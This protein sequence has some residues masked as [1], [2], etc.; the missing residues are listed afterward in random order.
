AAI[1]GI[2]PTLYEAAKIDGA[3]KF[4]QIWHITLPGIR[5]MIALLAMLSLGNILNAGFD[6]VYNLL[7]NAVLSTGQILDTYIYD[8]A[9]G[10]G[11]NYSLSAMAGLFKSTVG[12]M[13]ISL[14]YY[15]SYKFADY[16]LF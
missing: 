12:F 10:G 11:K 14:G 9:F 6:Q 13:L 7:N 8:L 5:G 2:D 15:L 3:N 1:V 16:K 4:E